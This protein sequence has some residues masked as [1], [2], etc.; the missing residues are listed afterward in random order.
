MED[1]IN[2]A[3]A[4]RILR[5]K[6]KAKTALG[7]INTI[8]PWGKQGQANNLGNNG[9]ARKGKRERKSKLKETGKQTKEVKN[10]P[11]AIQSSTRRGTQYKR[12]GKMCVRSNMHKDEKERPK[13]RGRTNQYL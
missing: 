5:E 6:S 3:R 10:K 9:K 4:G 11:D 8:I 13:Q 7:P 12:M 2:S 1:K